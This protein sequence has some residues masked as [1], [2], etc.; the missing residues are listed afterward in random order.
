MQLMVT[1]TTNLIMANIFFCPAE[2]DCIIYWLSMQLMMF[3]KPI[4]LLSMCAQLIMN[5]FYIY[6]Q[7]I[8]A[9]VKLSSD[10]D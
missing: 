6:F 9:D 8:I 7:K 5:I 2:V 3:I 4:Y 1:I 10:V